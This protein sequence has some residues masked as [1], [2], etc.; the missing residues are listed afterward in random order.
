MITAQT[1]RKLR[2]FPPLFWV[3]VSDVQTKGEVW[4]FSGLLSGSE[5]FPSLNSHLEAWSG[6]HLFRNLGCI[7]RL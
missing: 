3:S 1:T 4:V 7:S 5:S 2:S 6:T